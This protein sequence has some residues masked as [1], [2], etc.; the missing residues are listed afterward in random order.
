M[1]LRRVSLTRTTSILVVNICEYRV[2]TYDD[3][4]IDENAL[5]TDAIEPNRRSVEN[6]IRTMTPSP[7][8]AIG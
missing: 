6:A 4:S 3:A 7:F 5:V 1:C 2:Q 8:L